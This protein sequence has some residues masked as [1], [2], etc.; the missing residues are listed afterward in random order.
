[1]ICMVVRAAIGHAKGQPYVYWPTLDMNRSKSFHTYGIEQQAQMVEDR[2]RLDNNLG[3]SI[4]G[5][6]GAET[7]Y[8]VVDSVVDQVFPTPN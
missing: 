2:Y 7:N 5:N 3:V 4:L 1:M 6:K 8:V